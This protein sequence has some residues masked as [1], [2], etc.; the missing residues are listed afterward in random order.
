M[1]RIMLTWLFAAMI[2]SSGVMAYAEDSASIGRSG[3]IVKYFSE[4]TKSTSWKRVDEVKLNFR[5]HHTQ[6]LVKVGDYFYVSAVEKIAPTKKFE[7]PKDGYD[8]TPGEGKGYLFKFDDKGEL[9]AKAELGEGTI[10]HPGGIDYDGRYIWVPVAEYRPNSHSIIYRVDPETMDAVEIFRFDDHIGGVVHNTWDETLHG[11][12]WGSR[13]FYSWKF[14]GE[15]DIESFE[16]Y[17]E[18]EKAMNPS[19][20][21]DYQDCHYLA[22]K[23]MLCGGLNKYSVPELGKVALGGLELVDLQLQS[24][25]HQIPVMIFADS[26]RPMTQNPFFYEIFEDHL[27]FYFVPDDDESTLYIY[28]ALK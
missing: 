4:L 10:Y 19:H 6:G 2:V 15:T 11:V 14:R 22:D 3:T 16:G 25:V 13:R 8:R 18:F 23:Y 17:P 5:T 12:S 26:G 28:D 24:P 27:R 1:K 7:T 20:Y 9:I 21:I